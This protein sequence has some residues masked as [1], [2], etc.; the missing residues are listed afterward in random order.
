[1]DTR[2]W[3][4]FA[5]EPNSCILTQNE[6]CADYSMNIERRFSACRSTHPLL[7]TT[8]IRGKITAVC[9]SQSSAVNPRK[10]F[11]LLP[12][13]AAWDSRTTRKHADCCEMVH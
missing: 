4:I 3:L 8:S 2:F 7:P 6:A 11:D 10:R 5:F 12:N 13:E 9:T 1:M